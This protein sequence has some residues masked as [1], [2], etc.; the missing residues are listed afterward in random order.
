MNKKLIFISL[1]I[2]QLT[3]L[4]GMIYFH[5]SKIKTASKILLET[6]PVDPISVFR[7]RYVRLN[8][9]ISSIPATISR[10]FT[11]AQFKPGDYVYVT[12]VKLGKFW[13]PISASKEKLLG[14]DMIYLR[15]RVSHASKDSVR[16][17]YGIESFFL[18]E[19][20]ADE[21]E[22][23]SRGSSMRIDWRE[24][25][26]LIKEQ[27]ERLSA[28]DQ[29]INK[30]GVTKT[31]FNKLNGELEQ[32]IKEGII[33]QEESDKI[34]RKYTESLKSIEAAKQ[35]I[36]PQVERQAT[37]LTVE[38]A[39]AKDGTGYPTKLFWEEKEYR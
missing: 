1:I 12:L 30:T 9:K 8:Y 10:D 6:E 38:V 17:K 27:L 39:V 23:L 21:I 15:G 4:L 33:A 34:K 29:R 20:S 28:E 5:T 7:G 19:Q 36:I 14:T 35:V 37:A 13:E 26:R 11:H 16:I 31:W 32:W 22:E 18:S 24:R 3:F 2:I 25:D